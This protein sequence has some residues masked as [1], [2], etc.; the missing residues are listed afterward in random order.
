MFLFRAISCYSMFVFHSSCL[1]VPF[2][3]IVLFW[4][5]V[6]VSFHHIAIQKFEQQRYLF[7][8]FDE[9]HRLINHIKFQN[10]LDFVHALMKLCMPPLLI[11]QLLLVIRLRW[12]LCIQMLVLI[13]LVIFSPRLFRSVNYKH[14]TGFL[15][16]VNCILM[17]VNC[18]ENHKQAVVYLLL[19]SLINQWIQNTYKNTQG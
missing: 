13:V 10:C 11:S 5:W 2:N 16:N 1:V 17:N 14:D 18:T 12:V 9:F 7:F 3:W 15:M 8:Y 4:L 6:S 19:R